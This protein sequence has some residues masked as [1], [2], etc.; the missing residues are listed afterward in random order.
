MRRPLT[1]GAVVASVCALALAGAA[2]ELRLVGGAFV[3]PRTE[4]LAC[5]A[6][7]VRAKGWTMT[8]TF[9]ADGLN[10][11]CPLVDIPGVMQAKFRFAGTE[12]ALDQLDNSFGNYLNFKT[13]DGRCPVIE[14]AIPGASTLGIPLGA[15]KN[16]KG[17]HQVT[18][19]RGADAQWFMTVDEA[20]DEDGLRA[21]EIAW[22]VQA[23]L[24]R[25]SDRVKDVAVTTPALPR[26]TVPDATPI[27]KS[28]QFWTPPGHNTWVGD[29][30][31]GVFKNRFH[32]FYL[33]DRRHHASK[34]G[35][36]G[37]YFAHVSSADL[38]HWDEHPTAVGL[39][40]WWQTL[41]TGT[42]FVWDGKFCLAYGLHT[43][44]FMPS[45]ETTEP[46]LKKYFADHGDTGVFDFAEL[47]GYPLGGAYAESEDGIHFTRVNKLI[48]SAQNPTVYNRADGR[49]GFVN[50]YGGIHGIYVSDDKPWG[51]KLEDDKIPISGDCPC[52]FEWNGHH[53]LLQ[54]FTHMAYNPD[55]TPGNWTDW[56]QTGDDVYDGLCVPMV[57][58]WSGDRR[59][60]AGWIVHPR[61]WGGW[62]A[63]HELVQ[64][65]DGKLGSKWLKESP[66][67]G[68]LFTFDCLPGE[69]FATG[70][71]DGRGAILEFS[72]DAK[73][74]RAQYAN[75]GGDGRVKRCVTNAE[76]HRA[77][78]NRN[79]A[80]RNG[81]PGSADEYA[82]ER[83]RGLEKPYTVKLAAYYD[84][85][86]DVT[87]F[88]AEIA[89][90]RTMICRRPGRYVPCADRLLIPF[91]MPYDGKA[92]IVLDGPDGRRVRNLVNG[93]SF[94]K[95]H[96]EVV[97]DGRAED[98]TGALPGDYTIRVVTHPGI[99]SD[100]KGCFAAGGEQMFSGFGPNHLPCTMLATMGDTVI[101]SALF[102]EGGNST[103]VLSHDGKLLNGYGDG[104]NLGNQACCYFAGTDKWFY[105]VREKK[106]NELEFH[107]YGLLARQRPQVELVGAVKTKLKGA[108]R[109]GEKVY[110][111]NALTQTVDV[112][113]LEETDGRARLVFTGESRACKVAGPLCADG[114][115]LVAAFK[116]EQVSIAV[117]GGELFA[118]ESGSSVIHVYDR[119]T[120]K[121]TRRIGEEGGGYAG[122]WRKQ[123]LVEPTA[124][125]F[126]AAG[127][128]WVTENRYNPKR[129][130]RWNAQT[131]ICD[132][133][134]IGSEK[135][136]SPGV[137]MDEEDAT[138]WIAHDTEWR[139][140][141]AKK[142]D[143]PIAAL[144]NEK[145]PQGETYAYP[146]RSA[147]TYRFVRRDGKTFVLGND[148]VTTIWEYLDNEKR[149][150]PRLMVGSSGF[151]S[152]MI[153]RAHTCAAIKAAY[154]TAFPNRTGDQFKY[155]E[156][157]LMV[158]RDLNGN[159][160]F[161][162]EEFTFAPWGTGAPC[163]WGLFASGL[164]LKLPF[165]EKNALSFLTLAY[166]TW[167][168]E[169][170]LAQK[171]PATGRIPTG[172][173]F[174]RRGESYNTV[175]GRFLFP[176][177]SP[178]LLAFRPDGSLDW[179]MT[180]P[181][182]GVH[183]SHDAPLPQP[184]EL[185]G[186][187]F[188]LGSVPGGAKGEYE[189]AAYKNNH[190]RIFF[191]T[192]DGLY[193][194]EI[195]SD[196]RVAASNDETYIGGESFG[197]SFAY[198]R[199]GRRAILTS[200]GGGY[201]W[202]EITHLTDIR[203]MRLKRAFSAAEL[204]RAQE[205]S[206]LVPAEKVR[207]A[208]LVVPDAEQPA[209]VAAW[210]SGDWRVRLSACRKQDRLRLV[211]SV[212]EPSPW[213]NHGTDPYLMFKTGDCVDFQYLDA[214]NEPCRLM[215]F[216]DESV[217]QKARAILYRHAA[218]TGTP[219]DFAS[220]WRSHHVGDVQFPTGCDIRVQRGE[221][222]YEVAF[223]VPGTFEGNR[224]LVCDFGVIFGDRDGT[225]NQSR[226]Y[227][228][229]KETGL[230]N[231]VPGEIMPQPK[232]WGTARLGGET[233]A[234]TAQIV[235][236]RRAAALKPLSPLVNPYGLPARP[237]GQAYQRE[238][239]AAG[240]VYD[241]K[242]KLIYASAG[243][244]LVVAMTRDGKP[245]ASY[246]LPDARAF[247]RFDSMAIDDASGEVYVLAGGLA[248]QHPDREEKN[249]GRLYR[250][251]PQGGGVDCLASN[252]CAIS[253][254]V[255]NGR[256]ACM[257]PSSTLV[258]VSCKD[259]SRETLCETPL[260]NGSAY[261]CMIDL[262]PEGKIMAFIEHREYY[263][264]SDGKVSGPHEL[265][266]E[267]EIKLTRGAIL[268]NELWSMEG[269]TVKRYDARVMKPAPGVV[270]GGASGWFIGHVEMDTGVHAVGM[271]RIEKDLY[272]V[273]SAVNSAVYLMRYDAAH[274]RLVPE[275]R[276]GG[277]SD[278]VNLAVDDDGH[279]V[280]DSLVWKWDDAPHAAT[281]STLVRM[282]VRATAV[283]PNGSLL[284]VHETHGSRIEFRH[285]RLSDGE[286]AIDYNRDAFPYPE[287]V[288]SGPGQVWNKYRPV[289]A[290]SRPAMPEKDKRIETFALTSSGDVAI[291]TTDPDGHPVKTDGAFCVHE[292]LP[293]PE[294]AVFNGLAPLP[295][296]R[297]VALV[298]GRAFLYRRTSQGWRQ[299]EAVPALDG[300]HLASDAS[301]LAVVDAVAGEVRLFAW[302]A[303]APHLL[304]RHGGL[305]SPR[306][307]ALRGDRLVVWEEGARRLARFAIK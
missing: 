6:E 195:F 149:L 217:P 120:Q 221:R 53:Y 39:D 165:L 288:E 271:C 143:E 73:L 67:P 142:V 303:G 112:Y 7:T 17:A 77:G 40:E 122:A 105:S 160:K 174:P 197:G 179:Y 3:R 141:A 152:H 155:D 31:A 299:G 91:D 18:I 240:P 207:P 116:P 298:A 212:E 260:R 146:P 139:I 61:G 2:A 48:H 292:Q 145:V 9:D 253:Q 29:V 114:D 52:E 257:T 261:P 285:G 45:E 36:G 236:V 247:D 163:G 126:D 129:I 71:T 101:A 121:E 188:P 87:L 194:D 211:F 176:T 32:I 133:E 232:K 186:M 123:R 210:R 258:W 172:C 96:H 243:Q 156:E 286:L 130:S 230:V 79:L 238:N 134:K 59:I 66:P 276:L 227:W 252:L 132:Y 5:D 57:A 10:A 204:V 100:F 265:F 25:F 305:A 76:R 254:H 60:I 19:R 151:Y 297:F 49:L 233:S 304:A 220:P 229:N 255:V 242:R 287:G 99:G 68:D 161:D 72:V 107:G 34:G 1:R 219:H 22:P 268:G 216:P 225:V 263:V 169:T 63:V 90:Q 218:K 214:A 173:M 280:A 85:K 300:S 80:D 117:K 248:A 137:G 171:Q 89:G 13:A 43:T 124:L 38:A 234:E 144:F 86:A 185:Q 58:P 27:R 64:Y 277:I 75:V 296:G 170:A 24:A 270:Y 127:S 184:G 251:R 82:I 103:L 138:R 110:L 237:D 70:F 198:D 8:F 290:F 93:I 249:A 282:P 30:V 256:L 26:P 98:K 51:W 158:W 259:G 175:D 203:E 224:R 202:Y 15:L 94:T 136:G 293:A 56:S 200:G 69:R 50:S 148:G 157:T 88:D 281:D 11:A 245:A 16:P 275:K 291:Y 115:R 190:G 266:G 295:D 272:A 41:G 140:D 84:P 128:L 62:L 150:K 4:T 54:G 206:P 302:D 199:K 111:A 269:S 182:P 307:V 191:I 83:I 131:G 47:K 28:I 102:T 192:S 241:A 135:Y 44:R 78:N 223:T 284:H 97:W 201:R 55:G 228:S 118:I 81:P 167:S 215:V 264:F 294:K 113:R 209:Q 14:A 104:W 181:Y 46:F 23:R 244:G 235:P 168:L 178:Y 95:G 246:S 177:L 74:G 109:I 196:C 180:N 119:K 35:A 164:D 159:E 147:R 205:A 278:P 37:H 187:L 183:G 213:V 193:L 289:S 189:V 162:V 208:S 306:R 301:T 20:Y 239:Y 231:D 106:D 166:P 21:K 226:V 108:A 33:I 12:P 274:W 154:E 283:L 65:P 262:T 273:M 222:H 125:V 267:R 42:P 250:L 92:T 279:I 153:G